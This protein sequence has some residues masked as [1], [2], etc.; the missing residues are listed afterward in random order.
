[1]SIWKIVPIGNSKTGTI[2]FFKWF[3]ESIRFVSAI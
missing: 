3:A 1:M 2:I